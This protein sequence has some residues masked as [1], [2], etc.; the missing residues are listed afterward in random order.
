MS[1]NVKVPKANDLQ[2]P[3][4]ILRLVSSEGLT[5]ERKTLSNQNSQNIQNT[6]LTL[7]T[8]GNLTSVTLLL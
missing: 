8:H 3:S 7:Q 5:P 4:Y 2:I 1:K 6:L